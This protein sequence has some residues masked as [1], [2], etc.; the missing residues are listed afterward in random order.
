LALSIARHAAGDGNEFGAK[1]DKK[2]K[3]AKKM[4]KKIRKREWGCGE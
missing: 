3:K 4:R 1:E 2:E